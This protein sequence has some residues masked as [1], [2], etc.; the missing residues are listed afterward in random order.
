MAD[1]KLSVEMID[2]KKAPIQ[3]S[4]IEGDITLDNLFIE[5]RESKEKALVRKV[6]IR[7]MP[8]MMLLCKYCFK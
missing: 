6:D 3:L 4:T 5:D 2:Q 1:E 7:M 8:L